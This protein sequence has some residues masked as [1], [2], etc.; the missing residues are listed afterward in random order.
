ML[1]ELAFLYVVK[2]YVLCK[3]SRLGLVLDHGLAWSKYFRT[4]QTILASYPTCFSDRATALYAHHDLWYAL[5][6]L[7]CSSIC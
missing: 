7:V 2:L 4:E 1:A 6:Q 3:M 5:A